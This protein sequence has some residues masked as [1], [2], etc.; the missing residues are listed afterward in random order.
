M[1]LF[2]EIESVKTENC[3]SSDYISII[4]DFLIKD[5]KE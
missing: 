5:K 2:H 3:F 1:I 4:I